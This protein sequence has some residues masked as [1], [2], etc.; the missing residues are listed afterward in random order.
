MAEI[1]RERQ[2]FEEA[3][4]FVEIA[5]KQGYAASILTHANIYYDQ[6]VLLN[7][8]GKRKEAFELLDKALEKISLYKNQ[9]GDREYADYGVEVA[10]TIQCKIY[11]MKGDLDKALEVIK[12]YRDTSDP[13]TVYEQSLLYML[14]SDKAVAQ[15][16]YADALAYIRDAIEHI[17]NY[18][19]KL[20]PQLE[21]LLS[22]A[23]DKEAQ[24]KGILGI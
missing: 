21:E 1:Q 7:E 19:F 17:S 14:K 9:Y 2:N 8:K 3:F 13:Y 16:R 12:P 22:T 18:K 11:R 23:S 15:S 10:D 6:A 20:P 5:Q 24:Y 4:Y